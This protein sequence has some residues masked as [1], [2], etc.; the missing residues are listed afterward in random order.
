MTTPTINGSYWFK[1]YMYSG[2]V[3]FFLY[4]FGNVDP[5]HPVASGWHFT[6]LFF[7]FPLALCAWETIFPKLPPDPYTVFLYLSDIYALVVIWKMLKTVALYWFSPFVAP[8]VLLILVANH[9]SQH[10]ESSK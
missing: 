1:K 5:N 9:H 8:V 4:G 7:C 3:T 10:H 2:V 6:L